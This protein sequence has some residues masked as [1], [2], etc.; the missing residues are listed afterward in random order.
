[1]KTF[2]SLSEQKRVQVLCAKKGHKF[3]LDGDLGVETC[4]VCG[5]KK[6]PK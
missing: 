2:A 6:E 1:M 4:T 3:D 5:T